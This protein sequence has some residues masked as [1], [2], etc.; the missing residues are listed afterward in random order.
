MAHTVTNKLATNDT[1]GYISSFFI[2]YGFYRDSFL[3]IKTR[4]PAKNYMNVR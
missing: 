3:A 4:I 2:G 1:T